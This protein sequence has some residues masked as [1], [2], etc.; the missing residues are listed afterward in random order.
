MRMRASCTVILG[1]CLGLSPLFGQA[2]KE[3]YREQIR[4]LPYADRFDY[5]ASVLR[6]ATNR[7][8]ASLAAADLLD[9][10]RQLKRNQ[11]A[12]AAVDRC[13]ATAAVG[14]ELY[15]I[16]HYTRARL[17]H[18][19]GQDATAIALFKDGIDR[20]WRGSQGNQPVDSYIQSLREND[21]P[22]FAVERFNLALGDDTGK[23]YG[24]WG[25]SWF[26]VMGLPLLWSARKN[27]PRF[28]AMTDVLPRLK[29][30]ADM[31]YHRQ[32]AKAVCLITDERYDEAV[33]LLNTVKT[34]L[35]A[36]R[37]PKGSTLTFA[38]RS[39]AYREKH[40][41]GLYIAAARL[42]QG[43]RLDEADLAMEEFYQANPK[44]YQF[45]AKQLLAIASALERGPAASH[46][47]ML[48]A[49]GFLIGSGFTTNPTITAAIPKKLRLH[50]LDVH[51][52]GYFRQRQWK[53]AEAIAD[54]VVAEYDPRLVACNN[55]LFSLGCIY[56]LQRRWA[57]AEETLLALING[58][59]PEPWKRAGQ[60]QLVDLWVR[61]E[62]PLEQ[63]EPLVAELEAFAPPDE[64]EL[65]RYKAIIGK[66]ERRARIL[67]VR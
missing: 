31:P 8:V 39:F 47:R 27:E 18:R 35:A 16:A 56:R 62:K 60:S 46:G 65:Y 63:I 30:R 53:E 38:Q 50:L 21:L 26:K 37:P 54:L 49:T 4:Q 25:R 17:L 66:Y 20:G 33:A 13:L 45:V 12:L 2:I 28:S 1:A 14:S 3:E 40:C 48:R 6:N 23:T 15:Q 11:D 67:G 29:D 64:A 57:K 32:I 59:T 36:I 61:T 52:G 42:L 51:M 22:L 34:T 19:L 7:P 58:N 43:Q 5:A 10:S 41:I 24:R 9:T 44:R 55:S